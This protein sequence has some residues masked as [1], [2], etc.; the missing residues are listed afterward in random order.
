MRG[1]DEDDASVVLVEDLPRFMTAQLRNEHPRPLLRDDGVDRPRVHNL[2]P[3]L[4]RRGNGV[5]VAPDVVSEDSILESTKCRL[6][7]AAYSIQD[8]QG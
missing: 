7:G 4:P 5:V 8:A 3:P 2:G 1:A 6:W